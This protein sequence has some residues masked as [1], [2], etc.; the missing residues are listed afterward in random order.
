MAQERKDYKKIGYFLGLLILGIIIFASFSGCSDSVPPKPKAKKFRIG[1]M[2]TPKGLNDKGFNDLAYS[3]L[4][5]AAS[6]YGV[7]T[8]I[9]EPS[10]MK[11]PE[12]SLR[13][14]AEQTFDSII[15]VG[16][17]FY[18]AIKSISREHPQLKFFVIDSSIEEGNIHGVS[19]R[20]DEGSFL[21]GFL[22]GTVSKSR[23]VGFVGGVKIDVILRFFDGFR[24]G[25]MFVASDVSVIEK[26]IAE[27]FSG[28]NRAELG[29]EIALGLYKDG[30][31]VIYHAAGASGLGVISAAVESKKYVI[32]VDMDQDSLAP[33]LVLTSM[34]KRV[35]RVVEDLVKNLVEGKETEKMKR[36]YGINDGAIDLTDFQFTNQFV[37]SETIKKIW[38]LRTGIAEGKLKTKVA[39][40]TQ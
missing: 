2:I 21:C 8:V 31:D 22:A 35:D 6:K 13:F 27:D 7:E 34:L 3:G 5:S 37:G 20:E 1:L 12:T 39:S 33:G 19:F 18:G 40:S 29:K 30:C 28:F 9:I 23:K 16:V 14:F 15:A 11:D 32:G 10:T 26:Y 4:K 24:N 38:E 36:S 17:A 25:V